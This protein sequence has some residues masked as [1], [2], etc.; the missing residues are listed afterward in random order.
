MKVQT[1]H[2]YNAVEQWL[3][4][5]SYFCVNIQDAFIGNRINLDKLRN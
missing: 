4:S 5:F 2:S 1:T 3:T